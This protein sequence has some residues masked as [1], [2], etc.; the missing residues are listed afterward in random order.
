MSNKLSVP[1][2]L[3][4]HL[5]LEGS[6][7]NVTRC[8]RMCVLKVYQVCNAYYASSIHFSGKKVYF[9]TISIFDSADNDIIV[10]QMTMVWPIGDNAQATNLSPMNTKVI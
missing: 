1:E 2:S 8:K 9:S 3:I 10:I 5:R 7:L 6:Y 4:R